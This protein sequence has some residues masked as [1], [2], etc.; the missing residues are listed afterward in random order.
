[1]PF[2]YTDIYVR[3]QIAQ[4]DV[5]TALYNCLTRIQKNQATAALQRW[6]GDATPAWQKIVVGHLTKMRS[7]VN[8]QDVSI[9]F[10]DLKERNV[11]TNA[12]AL[13]GS[14]T[15]I[16]PGSTTNYKGR[17]VLLDVAFK[18]KPAFLPLAGGL[19]DASAY[20]QSKFE[21]LIH[22][23]SHAILSTND[24]KLVSGKE[25]YG[26]KR[27]LKLVTENIALAKTNAENWGI[28][29]EAC[30]VRNTS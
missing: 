13:P 23:L 3:A 9:G 11:R 7:I 20:N 26:S 30:G 21:T 28:F 27:A 5:L 2:V 6:F 25:A 24:E 22:E 10:M 8:L 12:A 14:L 29:V 15:S 16:V 17:N 1:M 19:I 18:T 4:I